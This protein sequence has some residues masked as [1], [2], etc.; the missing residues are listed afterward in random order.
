MSGGAVYNSTV[1]ERVFEGSLEQSMDVTSKLRKVFEV[2]QQL[3]GLK[4]RLTGAEKFLSEQDKELKSLDEKRKKLESE[5]KTLKAQAADH[6]GEV[7]RLDARMATI[8]SQMD[9]AQS[10][11]EYKA[12]LTELNTLKAERDRAETA[13]LELLHKVDSAKQH[14]DDVSGKRGEREKVRGV[15]AGDRDK[16]SDEISV[17]VSELTLQRD[18]LAKDV[19]ADALVVLRRLVETRGEEAMAAVEII[20]VKRF[21]FHCSGCQMAI[22]VD[23]VT[24]LITTGSVTRCASCQ[25][26]L[27]LEEESQKAVQ[28]FGKKK[29]EKQQA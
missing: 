10:N 15:A 11:K 23:A 3:R 19:P 25:C 29:K 5:G 7:K 2:E 26:I 24:N 8:R 6:E 4:S 22:P 20:D 17:R 21:E 13:A 16:K 12:F 18:A 1:V 9:N 14:L 28:N 27:F